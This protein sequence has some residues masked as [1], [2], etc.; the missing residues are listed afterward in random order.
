MVTGVTNHVY[1]NAA[2]SPYIVQIKMVGTGE[3][4][5]V[6]GSDKIVVTV[7]EVPVL[8]VSAGENITVEAGATARFRGTFTRPVGVTDLRYRWRLRRRLGRRGGRP[9]RREQGRDGARSTSTC[10]GSRTPRR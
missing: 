1:G 5:V 10:G 6:E 7:T 3:A 8:L 2:E 4:G 9:R